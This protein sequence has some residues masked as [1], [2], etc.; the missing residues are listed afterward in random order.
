MFMGLGTMVVT[1]Y[2]NMGSISC[3]EIRHYCERGK[4]WHDSAGLIPKARHY[5]QTGSNKM[6]MEHRSQ[7]TQ[8]IFSIFQT[9]TLCPVGWPSCSGPDSGRQWDKESQERCLEQRM[10]VT[11]QLPH[12]IS[13]KCVVPS[14]ARLC[15]K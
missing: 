13:G 1:R 6:H 14:C 11:L 8:I 3:S 7:L 9:H 2:T 5:L 10:G 12:I 4:A 15:I